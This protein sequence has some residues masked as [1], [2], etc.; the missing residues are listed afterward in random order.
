MPFKDSQEWRFQNMKFHVEESN[1]KWDGQTE[2]QNVVW[3]TR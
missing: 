3:Y 1:I 2:E